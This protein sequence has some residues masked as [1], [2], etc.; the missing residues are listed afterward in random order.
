MA[1]S[2]LLLAGGAA[3]IALILWDDFETIILPRSVM[4]RFRLSRMLNS[5]IWPVWS[6]LVSGVR[7][8]AR[9]ERYLGFYGPVSVILML[10]IW[11]SGLV[12][13]F[14]LV[15]H[16]LGSQWDLAPGR[17]TFWNDVYVSG[18]TLFTLGLGDVV[19]ASG[20][21]RALLVVEAAT[22][23]GFLAAGIAYLPVL[24]QSFSRREAQITLL[25]AWAGSPPSAVELLRRLAASGG[26]SEIHGFLKE[27]ER[28][29]AEVLEGHISYPQ[30]AYFRSQHGKQS[31][32]SALTAVL[33]VSAL[34][35]AGLEDVP[36]WQARMTFAIA[37]H[38]VVDLS[39]VLNAPPQPGGRADG[40]ACSALVAALEHAGVRF[41]RGP[42]AAHR[43]QHYRNL[44][45]P[46]VAGLSAALAMPLP[47][48][49]RDGGGHDNWEATP[50]RDREAMHL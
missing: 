49:I 24:Y 50:K 43:L 8:D 3:L 23:L 5:V 21:M 15:A 44:Y 36:P 30:V 4:R 20:R 34:V 39:Q 18:T 6:A 41:D 19:P 27:W 48:W 13:G 32:V 29:C 47:P 40:P 42:E 12:F 35:L 10:M 1:Q 22:G 11:V 7:T 45:E 14:A 26:L 31:W 37:R 33:D 2:W 28:W 16:G 9:R 46:Y 17:R 38:T 25:D